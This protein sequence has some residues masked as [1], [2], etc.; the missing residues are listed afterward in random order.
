MKKVAKVA[1]EAPLLLAMMKVIL[2]AAAAILASLT[3]PQVLKKVVVV[4][5]AV[6]LV[7]SPTP[8]ASLHLRFVNLFVSVKVRKKEI[9]LKG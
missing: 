3:A 5:I 2:V 1:T 4:T 8:A 7:V 6:L 9:P